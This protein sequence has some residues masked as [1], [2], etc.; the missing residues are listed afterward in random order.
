MFKTSFKKIIA[1]LLLIVTIFNCILIT[2][3]PE[4]NA[5]S[6]KFYNIAVNV[7][8]DFRKGKFKYDPNVLKQITNKPYRTNN[9]YT[10]RKTKAITD[11]SH[12]VSVA[13]YKYFPSNKKKYMRQNT[14]LRNHQL[15]SNDFC[16]IAY[17]KKYGTRLYSNADFSKATIKRLEGYFTLPVSVPATDVSGNKSRLKSL[18]KGDIIIYEGHVEIFSSFKN[19]QLRV[20][21]C[22]GASSINA[23]EVS[24]SNTYT[25][26]PIQYVL[27]VK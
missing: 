4:V 8:A 17:C 21:N 23:K 1:S 12:F 27:R 22:G 15:T 3:S 9:I 19:N 20:L 25:K 5:D 7:H 24:I 18:K 13:L 10:N 16:N 6:T 26:K 14:R 2:F 11:C